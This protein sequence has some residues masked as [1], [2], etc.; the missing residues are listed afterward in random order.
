[1]LPLKRLTA[2][3][4]RWYSD[5]SSLFQIRL[6]QLA[7]GHPL[8]LWVIRKYCHPGVLPAITLGRPQKWYIGRSAR[9]AAIYPS[10]ATPAR[11]EPGEKPRRH[12]KGV[13]M[14][15]LATTTQSIELVVNGKSQKVEVFPDT[16]LLWVLRDELG[17]TGTKFGCGEG[18]C[19]ACTVLIAGKPTRSCQAPVGTVAG[20]QITTI[21]GLAQGGQLTALQQ[22]W[23]EKDAM[24][25]AYCT[26]GFIMS[27]TALLKTNPHPT[28]QQVTQFLQGNVCRC[29]THPRIVAAVLRAAE[30]SK[31]GA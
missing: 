30:L 4:F 2:S 24:Q 1:M 8:R 10:C 7:F 15:Q 3:L 11:G 18:Q 21:E 28:A 17:L 23:V 27:S 13:A 5:G 16:P 14:P 12:I 20:K 9:L 31:E 19:G 25:C 22:A 6:W 26:S 29:G